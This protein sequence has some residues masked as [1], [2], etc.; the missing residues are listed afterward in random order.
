MCYKQN[1]MSAEQMHMR[2]GEQARRLAR[3]AAEKKKA[4]K[5]ASDDKA[6]EN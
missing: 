1:G 6:G 4:A 5:N 3:I 2:P